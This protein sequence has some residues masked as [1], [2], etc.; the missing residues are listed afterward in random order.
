[1]SGASAAATVPRFV[2]MEP[3]SFET[4]LTVA[5]LAEAHA[6]ATLVIAGA[7]FASA[8]MTSVGPAFWDATAEEAAAAATAATTPSSAHMR[9]Q[10]CIKSPSM[11]GDETLRSLWG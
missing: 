10:F 2:W 1:M 6:F 3:K 8:Q 9:L 5:P 7:R 11:L 4:T